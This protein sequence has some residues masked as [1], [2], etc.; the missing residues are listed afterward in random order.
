MERFALA[1][2]KDWKDR[3]TRRPLVVRGARQ[4]GKSYLVREFGRESFESFVAVDFERTPDAA[5]LFDTRDPRRILELLELLTGQ[6]IEPGRCLLFL[7]EVQAAPAALKALRYFHEELPEL[8][9]IAAG[10]LLDVALAQAPLTFPVGRIEY[11]HLGPLTFEEYLAAAGQGRLLELLR[12]V[13]PDGDIPGPIHDQLRSHL[14]RFT[15]IGG[16]PEPLR[17]WLETGSVRE[18]D[19]VKQALLATYE[20]D[21]A[22]YGPRVDVRRLT[23]VYRSLP[24]LA[25]RRFKYVQVDRDERARDLAP[26]LDLLCRAR[27]ASRV[28]RSA[29]NGPPLAAEADERAFKLLFL[30]VGLAL[31]ALGLTLL[32]LESA[33]DILLVN[34]GAVAEQLVGQHLLYGREP[35]EEPEL[36]FWAREQRGAAAEVD[37]VITHGTAVIPIEVK[38]GKTGTLKSLHQFLT[39]KDRRLGVRLN[40]EPPSLLD[41][42]SVSGREVPLRLL[43]LPLY[44]VGQVRRLVG[45]V[46][47]AG[48]GDWI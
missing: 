9:V 36:H 4:V 7:D 41:A 13:P 25:A 10:S 35:Y 18:S 19:I 24:R 20:D 21:F 28:L 2:L 12:T 30:D 46:L 39:E 3:P 37:F 17:A 34:E 1:Y 26:A 47:R 11:L 33:A 45:E 16:M 40:S 27:I 42:R 38:A 29:A 15:A 14:R 48:R 31:R 44:L 5:G 8:H 22:K 43:S 32:D 6:R 23:K